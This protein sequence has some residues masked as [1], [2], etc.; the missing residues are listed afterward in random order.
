MSHHGQPPWRHFYNSVSPIAKYV[1]LPVSYLWPSQ[2]GF[3]LLDDPSWKL[4]H[5]AQE[6]QYH[7]QA[8]VYWF[9]NLPPAFIIFWASA[10]LVFV[11]LT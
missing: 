6:E 7:T 5:V 4:K 3:L 2:L 9:S 11:V 8:L 10:L 1:K